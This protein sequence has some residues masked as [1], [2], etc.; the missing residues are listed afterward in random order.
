MEATDDKIAILR[1]SLAG[2]VS[3][4]ESK[5]DNKTPLLFPPKANEKFKAFLIGYSL[6]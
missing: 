1:F 5:D 3:R 2:N 6:F 4:G